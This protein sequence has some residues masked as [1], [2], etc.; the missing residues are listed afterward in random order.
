M[1]TYKVTLVTPDGEKVIE[2]PEDEIILDVAEDQGLDLPYSCRAGACSS[3]AGKV[4]SGTV[5]QD[6]QSFLDDDQIEQGYVLTC[7]A[8]PT[9][10]CTIK[11][12]VEEDL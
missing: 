11:T 9:S 2:C 1:A 10:D 8:K 3:C 6:D 5:D 12:N 7:V 4:E